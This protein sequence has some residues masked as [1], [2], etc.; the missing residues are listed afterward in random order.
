[1][2]RGC[3]TEAVKAKYIGEFTKDAGAAYAKILTRYPIMD[4]SD[5]AKKRLAALHQP[6]P[7]PTKA[8]VAQ[9]KAEDASRRE[10]TTAQKLMGLDEERP[11]H[12]RPPGWA[13]RLWWIRA[14]RGNHVVRR[15]TAAAGCPN[16]AARLQPSKWSSPERVTP[17]ATGCDS[18]R[19]LAVRGRSHRNDAAGPPDPNELKPNVPADP[20]ELKP[21]DAGADPSLPPPRR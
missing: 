2:P 6:I 3:A 19:R 14:T 12:L 8:A 18:T 7:R 16:P 11:G 21:T 5:D 9:N 4:R 15:E 13:N 17:H 20:N 1:M 10:S